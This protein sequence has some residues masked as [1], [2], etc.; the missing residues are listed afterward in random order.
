[1]TPK[2]IQEKRF[3]KRMGGYRSEEVNVYLVQV[4][5]YVEGI[6]AERDEIEKKMLVLAEKL[7][8]YR[9]DEESMRSAL[10]GAQKLGDNVVREA[11]KKAEMIIGE[12]KMKAEEIASDARSNMEKEAYSLTRMQSEVVDFRSQILDMYKKH[13]EMIKDIPEEYETSALAK[14]ALEYSN[15]GEPAEDETEED[16]TDMALEYEQMEEYPEEDSDEGM[17]LDEEPTARRIPK[18]EMM[19]LV[20]IGKREESDRETSK[21]S[22]GQRE[23]SSGRKGK[24]QRSSAG[25]DSEML[26]FGEQ[27]NLTRNE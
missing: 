19:K 23:R 16:A 3:E 15:H 18:S 7:E 5:T 1:M 10:I 20:E 12:A 14:Q 26:R 6:L 22:G 11:K 9:E 21:P 8:E 13:I 17:E 4:A 24:K 25:Y 27:Y 2:E